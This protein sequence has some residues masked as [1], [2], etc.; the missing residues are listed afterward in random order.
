MV[1]PMRKTTFNVIKYILGCTSI[2]LGVVFMLKSEVGLSSWDTLH[3]SLHK[4]TGIT[5][6]TAT[7]VVAAIF[8]VIVIIM[9]QNFKYIF[10]AIP[11]FIVGGLIDVFNLYVFSDL[12][13]DIMVYS[14]FLF[15]SGIILLPL[16][17]SLLIAS[18]YP[19]GVFDEFMLVVMKK[20]NTSKLF[21]VRVIIEVTAVLVAFILGLFA[22]IGLGMIGFGTIV[23]SVTI[24]IFVREFLKLFERI[25]IYEN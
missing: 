11:I 23:F 6:G 4:L 17:G 12:N 20:F 7:I 18:T 14:I 21:Q 5:M 8:T 9:N 16:G 13:P 10:M 25:G 3:Y 1:K 15:I 22:G 24:G 19:A 2:A